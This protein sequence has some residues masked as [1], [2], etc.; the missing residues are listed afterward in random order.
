LIGA[1][2]AWLGTGG[3]FDNHAAGQQTTCE[4]GRIGQIS[5]F[6]AG[7]EFGAH[8]RNC[9]L[10]DTLCAHFGDDYLDML[11]SLARFI[12]VSNEGQEDILASHR[13]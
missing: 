4:H 9:I 7:L 12:V 13:H 11:V 1:G 2:L 5:G 3:N 6:T 8:D 10:L